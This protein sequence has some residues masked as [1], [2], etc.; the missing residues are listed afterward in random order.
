VV[1]NLWLHCL[2]ISPISYSPIEEEVLCS[3]SPHTF[4]PSH[5]DNLVWHLERS[6]HDEIHVVWR[7]GQMAHSLWA[8]LQTFRIEG[9][10]LSGSQVVRGLAAG[11]TAPRYHVRNS[12]DRDKYSAP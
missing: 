3:R 12:S 8:P 7:S 10:R 11:E 9:L 6:D 4:V 5:H 2:K 1:T